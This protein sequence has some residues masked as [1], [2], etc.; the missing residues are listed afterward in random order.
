[1]KHV[2][3]TASL[4]LGLMS[5]GQTA[6]AGRWSYL[7]GVEGWNDEN[8][9]AHGVAIIGYDTPLTAEG[10]LGVEYNTDTL[11]LTASGIRIAPRLTFSAGLTGEYGIAGLLPDYYQG[12]Q[13][14]PERGFLASYVEA[15]VGV[16]HR[17]ADRLYTELLFQGR[18]WF[19]GT[20]DDTSDNFTLPEEAWV[21]RPRLRMTWWHLDN[22]P[23]WSARH[24][25][26]PR[27]KGFAIGGEIGVNLRSDSS[28]WGAVD[29]TAFDQTDG[30]NDANSAPI[31]GR[32]WM[33]A[34]ALLGRC[35]RV[36]VQE[37][38]AFG[39]GED[40]LTRDR[41]GGMNPYVTPLPGAPWASYLSSK[42]I[43]G[44]G[45]IKRRFM[46]G[47]L[48]A[49]PVVSAI[50]LEDPLR[51]DSGEYDTLYGVG[52]AVDYRP[53]NWQF[54]LRGGYSPSVADQSDQAAVSVWFSVGWASSAEVK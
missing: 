35:W 52:A 31:I 36:E 43:S 30:R 42:Y 45:A 29:P 50:H 1:M 17:T 44:M 28:S 3:L 6:E 34:G 12:G 25:L 10:N 38:A 27:L 47:A 4:S 2:I 41:L 54:D 39:A 8:V 18:K 9:P 13:T 51:M 20:N 40:D 22:D 16:K 5:L 46:K 23:G 26:F 14:I 11:R 53:G 48:E 21:Y 24:R 15:A 37:A 32:Q 49:G 33:R 19:F 7:L